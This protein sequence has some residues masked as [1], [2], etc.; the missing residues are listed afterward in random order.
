MKMIQSINIKILYFIVA[1]ISFG[2]ANNSYGVEVKEI[3]HLSSKTYTRVVVD[4]S[5]ETKYNY[6]LLKKDPSLNKP[7][8]LFIDIKSAKLSKTIVKSV[9]I[10]DG[11][12][13]SVRAGQNKSTVVRVV[14]DLDSV[15]DVRVFHLKSPFRIVIDVFSDGNGIKTINGSSTKPPVTVKEDKVSID[16]IVKKGYKS[17][18]LKSKGIKVIVIDAGHGG[19]DPGAMS[20]KKSKEKDLTLKLVKLLKKELGKSLPD[21]KI[22]L[23]RDKD[24]FIPLEKRTA[25]ANTKNADLFVSIHINAS[26]RGQARGL[27]T[28]F[29]DYTHDK[30]AIRVAARENATTPS[31]MSDLEFIIRDITRGGNRV[32]S[33]RLAT[34]VQKKMI[35]TL[36]KK[37]SGIKNLG[38]KGAPFYVLVSSNMP[39]ILV[40]V[41]FISNKEEEKRLYNKKYQEQIIKGIEAGILEYIKGI[42]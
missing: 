4:V 16:K 9:D 23:T 13:K 24:V 26:P 28:Y 21:T 29:L 2:F 41:G 17:K 34:L 38:V 19:K 3:R 31:D 20:R 25:I 32:E 27:E 10:N 1:F 18:E 33:S 12:L 39:S 6:H 30:E 22:I 36:S 37:Y 15:G 11:L 35:S 5:G 42:K 8:R 7:R 14:L 40:E